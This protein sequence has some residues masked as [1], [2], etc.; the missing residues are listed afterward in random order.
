[1]AFKKISPEANIRIAGDDYYVI[2]SFDVLR[3]IEKTLQKDVL[4]I[5]N[6]VQTMGVGD[7]AA[8]LA[9]AINTTGKDAIQ[10]SVLGQKLLDLGIQGS[11]YLLLKF[12]V[13]AWLAES[14]VPPDEREKKSL[15]MKE[16][17]LNLTTSSLGEPSK[18][19]A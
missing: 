5:Q 6:D 19:S 4:T 17:R 15:Q 9:A 16:M 3:A 2:G 1:M 10:E 11:A 14:I 13:M 7:L 12:D 8:L 18:E